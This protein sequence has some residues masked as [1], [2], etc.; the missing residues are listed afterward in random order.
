[1]KGKIMKKNGLLA[2]AALSLAATP[3]AATAQER[4]IAPIE[5]A[6]GIGAEGPM[7]T[8]LVALA[9]VLAGVVIFADNDSDDE[10]VSP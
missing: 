4:E 1:M 7:I 5:E 2:I 3:I 9:A 6:S 10:P 8:A